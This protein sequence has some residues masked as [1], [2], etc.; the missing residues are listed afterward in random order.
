MCR[1]TVLQYLYRATVISW[2]YLLSYTI[3]TSLSTTISVINTSCCNLHIQ[4]IWVC[5]LPVCIHAHLCL[6]MPGHAF[7]TCPL[8]IP[9][10]NVGCICIGRASLVV[11]MYEARAPFP[12]QPPPPPPSVLWILSR[13]QGSR[14]PT[15][16]CLSCVFTE[17]FCVT[18]LDASSL[19]VLQAN[20]G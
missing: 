16:H 4:Q 8:G 1:H 17:T 18:G 7:R 5:R 13:R 12:V 3:C 10:A 20:S 9:I 6:D 2:V 14:L 11:C 15:L 19:A